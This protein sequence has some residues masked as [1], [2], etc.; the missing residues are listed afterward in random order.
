MEQPDSAIDRLPAAKK[1]DNL[2]NAQ[3]SL[4]SERCPCIESE[5]SPMKNDLDPNSTDPAEIEALIARL[6]RGE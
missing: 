2:K 4:A 1:R 5:P 3:I 6:E